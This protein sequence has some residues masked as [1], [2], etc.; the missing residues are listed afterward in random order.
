[1]VNLDQFRGVFRI[2]TIALV[3]E[4]CRRSDAVVPVDGADAVGG[5]GV[6]FLKQA[7]A[8][9][10]ILEACEMTEIKLSVVFR[11]V[12][13]RFFGER[14]PSQFIGTR[15]SRVTSVRQKS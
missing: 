1:M 5:V 7:Y 11:S 2:Q 14:E 15:R 9:N 13:I 4:T 6:I 12:E 10:L 3:G 8:Q